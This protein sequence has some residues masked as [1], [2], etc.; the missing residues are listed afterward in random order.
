MVVPSI[1]VIHHAGKAMV[2]LSLVGRRSPAH[3]EVE[4]D[5]G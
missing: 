5:V 2:L 4:G 1:S 3:P